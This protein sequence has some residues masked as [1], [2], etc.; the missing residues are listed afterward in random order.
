VGNRILNDLGQPVY[1]HGVSRS[2][3][4]YACVENAGIFDGPSDAAS[5]RAI[6]S[7]HINAVRL[8]LNEDCWLGIK[9]RRV[10]PHYVGAPY[11]RA[12]LRYVQ[13]LNRLGM[14]AILNLHES[15]PGSLVA[16]SQQPMP[17]ADH[18]PAFWSS[19][20]RTFRSN[21]LVIF[22]LFDEPFP[23]ND[24]DTPAAWTCWR[25][26]G[27]GHRR[28]SRGRCPDVTYRDPHDRDTG[29]T[30][31]AASMQ[32]LVDAVRRTGARQM[33]LLDGVQYSDSL[34]QWLANMPRD[35]L[36]NLAA[37][38]HPYNFNTCGNDPPCWN[39]SVAPVAA[40]LPLV[41]GE[42][43][44]DDC[45]HQYIDRLM[46]WLDRH[47]VSYLAWSWNASGTRCRPHLGPNGDISV[48]ADY[49]GTPFP[50]MGVG[51][52]AHLVCL[53]AGRCR[54][55]NDL[56]REV[57]VR[58]SSPVL[59]PPVPCPRCWHP[60]LRTSWQWQLTGR[61]DL[62]VR[63]TMYD[64]DLFDTPVA[65]VRALHARHRIAICYLDAGSWE[66]WR[67]DARR[68]P[69]ALIGKLYKRWSGEWWLDI[70]QVS[71]LFPLMS[72]RLDRCRAKR[73]DGVELDNVDA[74]QNDTGFPLT[75]ADQLRY[76]TLLAN[77]AHRRGLSVAL[78]NDADQ[79]RALL[80]YFDWA[81]EEECFH[82]GWCT[83]LRPF[84][85]AG[86]AVMDAE[87]RLAPGAFCA[88]ANA[89]NIN[90]LV[91]RLDLGAYRVACR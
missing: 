3:A 52:K 36:H 20:A 74:Y 41:A 67:P 50:G 76:N 56:L 63:A 84:L 28:G 61:I 35:P 43:G 91:K 4:E 72:Q 2:G 37:S 77:Q 71:R 7:W 5:V 64:V 83:Q 62:S 11:R 89:M 55:R 9:A 70:R 60:R 32:S 25:L 90:A 15:A 81:L 22:D 6:A 45:S 68:F 78:K 23:D 10:N 21:S 30:Y 16:D 40:R 14:V 1:L 80:P 26:G 54:V 51:F 75:A 85:R 17:D 59:P 49:R 38:W 57:N 31:R 65:T 18:S 34:S 46:N 53:A 19:V 69:R 24:Q 82:D 39:T 12:I 79:A 47:G 29:I 88:R 58:R 42:I 8:P 44:E 48:I 87:Y 13:L 27:E 66:R 73:F 33:L 86:K